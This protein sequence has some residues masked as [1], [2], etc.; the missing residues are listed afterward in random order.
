MGNQ[1]KSIYDYDFAFSGG[2]KKTLAQLETDLNNIKDVGDAAVSAREAA[3]EATAAADKAVTA[4]EIANKTICNLSVINKKNDYT[5]EEARNAVPVDI[6]NFGLI[7]VYQTSLS[8]KGIVVEQFTG[9]L[10]DE[11]WS[12]DGYWRNLFIT[13]HIGED[14]NWFIG[15][16]NLGISANGLSGKSAYQIW[17]EQGHKGT[18]QDFMSSLKG[19]TGAGKSAY[20][21]WLD[22]GYTG[23]EQDFIN[24]L[25]GTG[26]SAYQIWLELGH[27]GS[28][29]DFL[30]SLRGPAGAPGSGGGESK[31]LEPTLTIMIAE[32]GRFGLMSPLSFK[33]SDWMGIPDKQIKYV[34]F[35]RNSNDFNVDLLKLLLS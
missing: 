2:S 19:D 9:G 23:T 24:S 15:D 34:G 20:Q 14:G 17:L 21:S 10:I 29:Q 25:K 18:E 27:T 28:E 5:R 31:I 35:G 22:S 26:K 8:A 16:T 6:R 12:Y 11:D 3:A 4:T 30:N 1:I 33:I 13:P 7:I 32:A